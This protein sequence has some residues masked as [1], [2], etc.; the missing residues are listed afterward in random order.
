MSSDGCPGEREEGWHFSYINITSRMPF[1]NMR[2]SLPSCGKDFKEMTSHATFLAKSRNFLSNL[3]QI[4][5]KYTLKW[6]FCYKTSQTNDTYSSTSWPP[7][8]Y[9]VFGTEH[10][11]PEGKY[12]VSPTE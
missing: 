8:N 12:L 4:S 1:D 10:G 2:T 6:N 5:D 3:L 11:C 9:S 7:G